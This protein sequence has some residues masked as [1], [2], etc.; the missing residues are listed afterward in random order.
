MLK[1]L[2]TDR[3]KFAISVFVLFSVMLGCS[4]LKEKFSEVKEEIEKEESSKEEEA[5]SPQDIIFHNKY[6]EVSKNISN[7]VDNIQN[8]YL[9][10]IPDPQK[11]NKNSFVFLIG[12]EVQ[13]GFLETTIKNY[14]RSL[15]DDGELS[16]LE[17]DNS[18]MKKEMEKSFE[19][20]IPVIEDYMKTARKVIDFYTDGEYKKDLSKVVSYDNEIKQKYEEYEFMFDVFSETINK[21]KPKRI[22]RNPD[23]YSDPD[24]KVGVILQNALENTIEKAESFNEE[25]R[26][27]NNNT[28]V[29]PLVE[30]LRDFEKT[31]EFEKEKVMSAE[32]SDMTKYMKYNYED[33]FSKTV[34]DFIRHAD[35]FLGKMQSRN[36]SSSEFKLVYNDVILYYNLMITSYNTT[37]VT[38]NMF[39]AY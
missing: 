13:L 35:K 27:I 12:P 7:A 14:K 33:Y 31:F 32:Y 37:L 8:G 39:Q 17:A 2:N 29:A 19:R 11:I 21:Y 9:N 23:D 24:E 5:A 36:L 18:E 30:K 25:F 38:I 4:F 15:Y 20:L 34:T 6:L 26:E 3:I 22:I 1:H 10:S 28:D 16:K